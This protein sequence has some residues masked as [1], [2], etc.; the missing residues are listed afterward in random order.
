VDRLDGVDPGPTPSSAALAGRYPW[1]DNQLAAIER[2]G[3]RHGAA[4]R[5]TVE[6]LTGL[7]RD[8]AV[9]GA[10]LRLAFDRAGLALDG[11]A[12]RRDDI[13]AKVVPGPELRARYGGAGPDGS[14]A[15]G[16]PT[17]I[18]GC[19]T[20]ADAWNAAAFA[21]VPGMRAG[22]G[23]ADPPATVAG[24]A[25][26]PGFVE[27]FNEAG[28]DVWV[29]FG[30][31]GVEAEFLPPARYAPGVPYGEVDPLTNH[32]PGVGRT[33]AGLP[34]ARLPRGTPLQVVSVQRVGEPFV[35]P[36]AG[37]TAPALPYVRS[38]P[39]ATGG[40]LGGAGGALAPAAPADGPPGAPA[41]SADVAP[42]ARRPPAVP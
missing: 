12:V 41:A 24:G 8:G 19:V 21:D 22:M 28:D 10:S 14:L 38:L 39:G 27:A 26:A 6:E 2:S 7:A 16:G 13:V 18:Q 29:V 34:E 33:P 40:A 4:V 37:A 20:T 11:G 15:S 9:D 17:T 32:V 23:L 25:P 1:L 30:R 36:G 35:A 31:V 3:S 42:S 5:M